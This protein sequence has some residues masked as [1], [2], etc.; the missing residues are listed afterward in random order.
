MAAARSGTSI[1]LNDAASSSV[2]LTHRCNDDNADA[3]ADTGGVATFCVASFTAAVDRCEPFSLAPLSLLSPSSLLS[4]ALLLDD[5]R[6]SAFDF[7]AD[8]RFVDFFVR[9]FRFFTELLLCP[10]HWLALSLESLSDGHSEHDVDESL[11]SF[12]VLCDEFARAV[13]L[14]PSSAA[15]SDFE[16]LLLLLFGRPAVTIFM[17]RPPTLLSALR[18]KTIKNQKS[19]DVLEELFFVR[20]EAIILTSL[21]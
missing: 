15:L 19:G 6:P 1:S 20:F 17:R 12:C 14:S 18:E 13:R 7:V 3:D 11:S 5:E 21:H 9:C 8:F 4:E 2:R 16:L 10:W